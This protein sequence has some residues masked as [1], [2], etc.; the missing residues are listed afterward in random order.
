MKLIEIN[1]ERCKGCTYCVAFCK[2]D[3]LVMADGRNSSG[4]NYVR[5][6]NQENCNSCCYCILMCPDQA[7]TLYRKVEKDR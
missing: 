1:Q 7:I 4:L 2:S 6:K 3:V 5:I